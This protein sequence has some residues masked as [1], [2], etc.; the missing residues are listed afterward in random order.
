MEAHQDFYH[1]L[2]QTSPFPVGIEITHA[3]GSWLYGPKN[4]RWLDLISGIGVNNIGHSHPHVIQAIEEQ[5]HKHMH[6]MVY[7]EF[8]QAPQTRFAK[9]LTS[10]LPGPLDMCYFV[11]SG[12]EAN[13]AAIKLAKRVTGRSELISMH[14][15]YHGSTN[16][17]LSISGNPTKQGAFQPLLPEVK[18]I[19]FN[20]H[21]DLKHITEETAG[22]FVEVIQG[23]AGVRIADA[24]YLKALRERCTE[25]G[26][27]L[28]IDEIQSGFGRTGEWFAFQHYDIIPDAITIGKAMAGGLAMGG[29]IAAKQHLMQFTE[30]PM[31][32]HITT[33]GGHPVNCAAGIANLAVMHKEISFEHVHQMG[34][35]IKKELCS[36]SKVKAVR[37]LGLMLAVDLNHPSEVDQLVN[38]CIE[39]GVIVYRFL[40]TA[41][42]FRLA[43]P[44]NI[45]LEELNYGLKVI[46]TGL[47]Q[48]A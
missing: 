39:N 12:T 31:L 2:A 40:S 34:A 32:G 6:V 29:L 43:P 44:L 10:L 41:H 1:H 20:S 38:Y 23:D 19:H 45:T 14:Q 21:K 27:L 11:N 28:I 15:S 13:E 18:F 33:F 7:G 36:H 9:E 35:H 26:A 30:K 4:Q 46:R 37:Q 47:D 48:L 22:V 16:G 42:A 8:M 24:D 3:K 25:T 5:I 17:S